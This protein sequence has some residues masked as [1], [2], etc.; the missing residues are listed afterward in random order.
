MEPWGWL[1]ISALLSATPIPFIKEYINTG[2]KLYL[3]PVT[4][5]FLATI[6]PFIKTFE[7]MD[8]TEGYSIIKIVSIIM[9]AFFD[10][11]FFNDTLKITDVIGIILGCI[12]I[13]LLI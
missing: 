11:I 3:I 4:I 6:Y 2:N 5:L 13:Y 7:N 1:F 12:A 8:A 9:V 10:I